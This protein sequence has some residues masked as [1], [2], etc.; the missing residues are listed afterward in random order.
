MMRRKTDS[1]SKNYALRQSDLDRLHNDTSV[2]QKNIITTQQD[3][4]A[5][6][7]Y[8]ALTVNLLKQQQA[9]M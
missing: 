3:T 1:L 6:P 9:L 8:D 4:A 5:M 2:L 7:F